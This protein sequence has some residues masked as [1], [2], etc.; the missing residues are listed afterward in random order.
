MLVHAVRSLTA[1]PSVGLVVVAAPPADVPAV[2]ALLGA[3]VVVVAGGATRADSVRCAMAALPSN[4]DVVLVHD[5]ARPFVP[6]AVVEAVIAA[7]RTGHDAVV[8][9]LA[10]ADT[11]KRV[12]ADGRVVETLS[13]SQLY[14]TQTPQGFRP[15]VLAAA[16]AAGNVAGAEVT[17]DAM[18]VERL[19]RQVWTVPGA[20]EAFKITRPDD[21]RRAEAVLAGLRPAGA[22]D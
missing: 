14:A 19:G 4:V 18:L 7:V 5:A 13:R 12:A 16:H 21:L 9:V 3:D 22:D 11:I 10:V 17:D 20:E 6:P 1:A 2:R 15:D 8:P